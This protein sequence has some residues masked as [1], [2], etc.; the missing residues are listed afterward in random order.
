MTATRRN[1]FADR[2]AGA[3]K[4]RAGNTLLQ[5]AC[6]HFHPDFGIQEYVTGSPAAV[7]EVFPAVPEFE[8]G[9]VKIDMGKRG[10]GV[11]VNE[12]EMRGALDRLQAWRT[13]DARMA[14]AWILRQPEKGFTLNPEPGSQAG[15]QSFA[16]A[17]PGSG[18]TIGRDPD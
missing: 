1:R 16:V 18:R 2:V 3:G 8:K 11:E 15:P 14:A 9:F 7:C 10:L 6:R 5:R 4:H 17:R 13:H 12:A